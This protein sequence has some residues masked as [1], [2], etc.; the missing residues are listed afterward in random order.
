MSQATVTPTSEPTV[1]ATLSITQLQELLS[2]T[3]TR[4]YK[5][6]LIDFV[7]SEQPYRD[8]MESPVFAGKKTA[9]VVLSFTNNYKTLKAENPNWPDIA[10]VA[11]TDAD[12]TEHVFLINKTIIAGISE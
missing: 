6:E 5:P 2:G 8:V 9:S 4:S 12:K 1:K 7:K 11:K 10:I 3:K